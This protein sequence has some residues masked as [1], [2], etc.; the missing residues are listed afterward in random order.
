MQAIK[1]SDSLALL[2]EQEKQR[3]QGL[4]GVRHARMA[5]SPFS[6]FRGAAAVMASDLARK[7]HSDSF[8]QLCGDAH[9]MNFGFY[10]SPERE[11]L[12]DINDFDETHPGPYEWDVVRLATSLVIAAKSIGLNNSKQESVCLHG[13]RAY[14]KAMVEFSKMPLMP[15]WVSHLCQRQLKDKGASK[16]LK[17]HLKKVIA[18]ALQRDSRHAVRK[19]CETNE[20]GELRFRNNPP[21]IWRAA[22]LPEQWKD[23]LDWEEWGAQM[24]A[25]YFRTIRPDLRHLFSQYRL[26]DNAVKVVGVGSVGTRCAISLFAGKHPDDVIVLQSKEA[27]QSILAPY[28]CTAA[29]VHQG[30]RVVQG[31]LLMQTASDAFLGWTSNP[32]GDQVYIRHFRDWK[33]SVDLSCLDFEGLSDYGELCAWALAKAHARTG[34]RS[35]IAKHIGT[36][37][38]FA[39]AMLQE[40]MQHSEWNEYDYQRLVDAIAKGEISSSSAP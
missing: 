25:D 9:L 15:M 33:G 32:N 34:D 40:A 14:A 19:L 31:Q 35:G 36:P 24:Y 13:M 29:P 26:V 8:V 4:L 21:L 30:E 20:Q 2:L 17:H 16:N 18:S 11:L 28:I 37:K 12:F 3:I 27:S 22:E 6:Y 38:K 1:R 39:V 10:A 7:P 5:Q 23:K